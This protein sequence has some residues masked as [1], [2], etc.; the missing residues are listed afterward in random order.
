MEIGYQ[1]ETN[2]TN[3]DDKDKTL[4]PLKNENE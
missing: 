2:D 4:V 3:K 1:Q